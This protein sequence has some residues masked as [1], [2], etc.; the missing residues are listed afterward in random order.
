MLFIS[1]YLVQLFLFFKNC[2]FF[3]INRRVEDE[4]G[5]NE[6]N[7]LST[8]RRQNCTCKRQNPVLIYVVL[9]VV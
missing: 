1:F 4:T 2:S 5:S 8:V 9:H 6:R 7:L 3:V